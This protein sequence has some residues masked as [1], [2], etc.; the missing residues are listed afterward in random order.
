[1]KKLL[2]PILSV[3]VLLFAEYYIGIGFLPMWDVL[4]SDFSVSSSNN[5]LTIS[6]FVDIQEQ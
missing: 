6:V 5:R 2:I 3:S 1:M 4:L